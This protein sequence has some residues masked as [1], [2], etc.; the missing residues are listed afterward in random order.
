MCYIGVISC[1]AKFKKWPIIFQVTMAARQC[2]S[3]KFGSRQCD[4]L[5][6]KAYRLEFSWNEIISSNLEEYL[7][8]TSVAL[9]CPISLAVGALL[10]VTSA[11]CGPDT[12]V[13]AVNYSMPLNTFSISVCA[14]GGGKSAAFKHLVCDATEK[15]FDDY[16][17]NALLETYSSAGHHHHT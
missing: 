7:N 16:G 5:Y 12:R 17:I 3:R 6:K 14:P 13:Q 1:K 4:P 2:G 8:L 15:V 9:N 11:F 10:P